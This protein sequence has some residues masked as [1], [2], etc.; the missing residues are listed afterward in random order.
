M[1]YSTAGFELDV[2]YGKDGA[3]L[4]KAYG[5]SGNLIYRKIELVGISA[6]YSGGTVAAGT[7]LDQLTGLVV[8]ATYDDGSTSAVTDYT[9]SGTLTAG[10]TNT[11]TVTYQGKT[12]TFEVAVES[13]PEPEEATVLYRF[14]ICSDLHVREA[15]SYTQNINAENALSAYQADDSINAI[16]CLGDFSKE[17]YG[18]LKTTDGAYTYPVAVQTAENFASCGKQ[19]YIITGNH[20]TGL[21][22]SIDA[23][24]SNWTSLT[25]CD[26][27]FSVQIPDSNFLMLFV[28]GI[29]W[30]QYLK[31][32][33]TSE[34]R[35]W[36]RGTLAAAK[37]AGKRVLMFT[38]YCY[39][40]ASVHFGYRA[41]YVSSTNVS[42][43]YV[44]GTDI[45]S[46]VEQ[47]YGTSTGGSASGNAYT[48][49]GDDDDLLY[50]D[51]AA[52]DNILWF[53]GHV[54]TP[55]KWQEGIPHI[56]VYTIPGGASMI[57]L[58]S[59][60]YSN[61]DALVELMS[62][63]TVVVRARKG[64]VELGGQYVYTWDGTQ[65]TYN[66]T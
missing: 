34:A 35:A 5:K 9:L 42:Q 54:H 63:G 2:I 17:Y 12:A 1:V 38:H 7:T 49:A 4:K 61:Q 50:Q 25:G 53:S 11:I 55:W 52:Y 20:D 22:S 14:P 62:D 65:V 66:G 27:Y 56:K 26:P 39:P 32:I 51:I 37:T 30:G 10:Q 23:D 19:T 29:A 45:D 6:S 57:N 13:E 8:T 46:L 31:P 60:G 28:S 41:G 3:E 36:V 15:T 33:Y 16:V 24:F 18:L 48:V 21:H 58:P 43:E 44:D 59:L 47:W 40:V 64:G